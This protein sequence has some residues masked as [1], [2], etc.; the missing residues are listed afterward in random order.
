ATSL[1]WTTPPESS[2]PTLRIV[3]LLLALLTVAGGWW[4]ERQVE[5]L[6][7]TRAKTTDE[8]LAQSQP[9]PAK[10][11]AANEARSDFGRWHFYSLMLNF[12]TVALVTIAMAL[13]AVLPAALGVRSPQPAPHNE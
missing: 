10:L 5:A 4:L 6:R 13:T 11:Q 3:A 7:E 2:W 12:V 8:V 9:T 1:S